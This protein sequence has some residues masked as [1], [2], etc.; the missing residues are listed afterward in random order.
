MIV[1][2]YRYE[3]QAAKGSSPR[4]EPRTQEDGDSFSSSLL[5]TLIID[6]PE[7]VKKLFMLIYSSQRKIVEIFKIIKKLHNFNP[8]KQRG[9]K[10]DSN[11]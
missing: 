4:Y 11:F 9:Q 10:S 1:A 2:Q 8:Y 7:L 6:L 3:Q 5:L